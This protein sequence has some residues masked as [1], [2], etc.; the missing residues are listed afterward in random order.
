MRINVFFYGLY[1]DEALLRSKGTEPEHNCVATVSGYALRI[2]QRATLV[3]DKFGTVHGVMMSLTYP[4]I[5]RLYADDSVNMYRPIPV[6]A[7]TQN[8]SI[9]PALCFVLPVAPEPD[10]FNYDYARKLKEISTIIG[11]PVSY[12]NS[13]SEPGV[14]S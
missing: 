8:G 4:E 10:E 13:I 11:L 5:D 1:M 14:E 3:P 7:H 9:I 6:V 12:I 2:G